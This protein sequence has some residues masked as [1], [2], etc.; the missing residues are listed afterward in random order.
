MIISSFAGVAFLLVAGMLYQITGNLNLDL[1][2]DVI[3][4]Y[5]NNKSINALFVIFLLSMLFKLGIY[6]LHSILNNIYNNLETNKLMVVAGV[7][8]IAYPPIYR[9][10]SGMFILDNLSRKA[11]ALSPM[12]VT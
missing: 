12:Y 7:S 3:V 9:V 8:S 4:K 11:N 1:M 5:Q 2:H 10:L 6:P